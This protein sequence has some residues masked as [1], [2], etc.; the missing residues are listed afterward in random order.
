MVAV[1]LL[2]DITW[3]SMRPHTGLLGTSSGAVALAM[4]YTKLQSK[5]KL[6]HHIMT[7]ARV[8]LPLKR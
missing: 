2:S 3:P 4:A 8:K 7:E 5:Y 1:S 6:S